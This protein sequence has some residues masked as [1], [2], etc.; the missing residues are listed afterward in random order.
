MGART[1]AKAMAAEV[2]AALGVDE[3][4]LVPQSNG[5]SRAG[6]R[7]ETAADT[8]AAF[9]RLDDGESGM[10][11]THFDL[12]RE[13]QILRRVRELGILVPEVLATFDDPQATLMEF[14]PGSARVDPA[15]VD[16]I[17]A[18]YMGWI[19]AIH[20]LDLSA[21][22]GA[23]HSTTDEA[24]RADL[25]W[26][27]CR[28]E[29][30]S[31]IDRPLVRLAARLLAESCPATVGAPSLVH[32]DVGPGN[33]LVHEG[34][35]S[36]VLDW[37]LA[38]LGDPHEDLAWLW[39]RGAHTEFGD[40][41]RR[42]TEYESA[43][44]CTVDESLVEWHVAFVMFKTVIAIRQRLQR[45]GGG[46]LVLTQHVLLVTYEA[47]LGSA[48]AKLAG[49]PLTLLTEEPDPR[50]TPERRL[51]ERLSELVV[52]QG[53]ESTILLEQFELAGSMREWA[54]DRFV[55][56]LR[57]DLGLGVDELRHAIDTAPTNEL[58]ALVDVIAR[59]ADRWCWAS[60]PAV[61]RVRRAQSIGL[62][63]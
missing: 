54:T 29:D 39:M 12:R 17:G 49:R 38:H 31:V 27:T 28:A 53:K 23:G 16:S 25:T 10:S 59:D 30:S 7:V 5:G 21:E 63:S 44:G 24:V 33:F 9:L 42:F 4:R 58:A 6:F 61:R 45:P 32:G 22:I 62:G 18:E 8:H 3:V 37:E 13:A 2:A 34:R 47:L 48:L 50:V 40:P 11:D 46:R 52:Q 19:A 56:Q 51:A 20:A 43:A 14:V 41:R 57:K 60:P 35:V 26:W 55:D 36:A 1:E 15:E